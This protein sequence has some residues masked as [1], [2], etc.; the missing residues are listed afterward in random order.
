M[1]Q[2][3]RYC[4]DK[5]IEETFSKQWRWSRVKDPY[6]MPYEY[7]TF[8]EALDIV[9]LCFRYDTEIRIV[10]ENGKIVWDRFER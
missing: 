2:I 1:F 9:K 6:G 7:K 4:W 5:T 10:N 8:K 3:S